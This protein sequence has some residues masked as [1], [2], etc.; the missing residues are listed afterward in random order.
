MTL[1]VA[2]T[3]G[4]TGIG[5]TTA[6]KLKTRGDEVIVFDIAEPTDH[7]DLWI[8][9]D[10]STLDGVTAAVD[11]ADGHFDVL[12][13][14]AGL[15]PREG[16]SAKILA[17][18]TLGLRSFTE[19]MLPRLNAG[20][21]IVNVAS[22]AGSKWRDNLDQVKALLAL[23]GAAELDSFVTSNS[24][25]PV[26]AYILS[27]EAVIVWTMAQTESLIEK[28]LRMN[29]VSPAAVSTGILD[30]FIKAFGEQVAKNVARVGRPGL[31]DEVADAIVFLS[32][33]ES[34][35]IKGQDIVV[36][37]G[38]SS[39]LGSEMLGLA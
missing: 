28:K 19:L 2:M 33:A 22:R 35:W 11:Q 4:A 16:Q 10:L 6:L 9:S 21:S 1:R 38:M 39:V 18:N 36:D 13:N 7:A 37:G 24:I 3:G 32:S 23:S 20:G 27:K 30:D 12:I 15:P 31:P 14:C 17:L 34:R 5:H 29:T 8:K 26:R 25:D